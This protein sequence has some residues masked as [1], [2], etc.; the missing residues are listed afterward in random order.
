[1]TSDYEHYLFKITNFKTRIKMKK[2]NNFLRDFGDGA[3]VQRV[4]ASSVKSS[5]FL[6]LKL[7]L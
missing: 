5:V 3:D 7:Q 6:S 2:V 4:F 1:M